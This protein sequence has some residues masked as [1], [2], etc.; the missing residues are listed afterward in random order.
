MPYAARF[1]W[2]QREDEH[3]DDVDEDG[4]ALDEVY[5]EEDA[6]LDGLDDLA[7]VVDEYGW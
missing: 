3:G 6:D 2:E 5:D 4:N 1:R 7:D